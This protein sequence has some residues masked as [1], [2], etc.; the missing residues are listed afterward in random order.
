MHDALIDI[1]DR[2][3]KKCGPQHWWPAESR[4]EVMIGAILVQNTAWSNVEKAIHNLS[5]AGVLSA[6][7]LRDIDEGALAQLVYPSGYYNTKARKL[8][9]F[10]HWLGARFDDDIDAMMN[11]EQSSLRDELLNIHGIGEETADDILLYAL[12]M[13]V[14]VIDAYTRRL[15]FRLGLAP[16]KGPY[17]LYQ[18]LFQDHLPAEVLAFNEYHALIV[19]HAA[20]VCKREPICQGCCLL[21][22]CPTGRERMESTT[23]LF[24]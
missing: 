7:D 6:Q 21:E 16:E 8:K 22:V 10:V 19:V 4:F 1:Y 17:A 15:F 18:A 9:A 3:Y 20:N 14:F 13:P 2:L 5:D 11:A 24:G 12:D 23:P